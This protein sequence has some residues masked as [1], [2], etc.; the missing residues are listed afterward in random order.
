MNLKK[1]IDSIQGYKMPY[2]STEWKQITYRSR[3]LIGIKQH[4]KR[5][6]NFMLEVNIKALRKRK[7]VTIAEKGE[8]GIRI[9]LERYAEF[10]ADIKAGYF[11]EAKSFEDIFKRM[12][13]MKNISIRWQKMQEATYRNH[14]KPYIGNKNIKEISSYDIDEVLIRVRSKAPATKK[15]IMNIVKSVLKYAQE[16][17][18]IK[19]LP[20][21]KRHNISVN[22]LEQ[23]TLVTNPHEK[24]LKVHSAICS[25]FADNITMKSIF[26]FGLY[27]RRKAEVLQMNWKQID[28]KNAQYIIPSTH[29]KIK[30]DFVFSL[31]QEIA[32]TLKQLPQP[33]RGLIF[34]NPR[35]QK[36]YTNIQ[37]EIKAIRAAAGW[38]EFTFHS[39]RNLLASTLHAR[40]VNASYISSVLGHTNPNTVKQYLT[41]ERTQTVIEEEINSILSA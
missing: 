17:K 4:K 24:F 20:L 33:K 31:P 7:F 14:I 15:S 38:K 2:N 5:A 34:V 11:V 3:K 29:S 30:T 26:L 25:V 10:K 23:K 19:V 8:S 41:M 40:G 35:T 32:A 22:A 37:R 16:E 18:I 21:E 39:M 28:F 36:R 13:L 12:L 9:A 27:G 6:N 1:F